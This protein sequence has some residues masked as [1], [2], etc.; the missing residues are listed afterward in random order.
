M[1]KLFF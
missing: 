1:R